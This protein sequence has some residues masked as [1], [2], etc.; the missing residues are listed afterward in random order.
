MQAVDERAADSPPTPLSAPS[1]SHPK[2]TALT[3]ATINTT[4]VAPISTPTPA[5]T[6]AATE[7]ADDNAVLAGAASRLPSN[8]DTLRLVEQADINAPVQLDSG[9]GSSYAS[10]TGQQEPDTAPAAAAAAEGTPLQ[11]ATHSAAAEQM[12][13]TADG[14]STDRY[15]ADDQ[16]PQASRTARRDSVSVEQGPATDSQEG[17]QARPGATPTT[18]E[19]APAPAPPQTLRTL[20]PSQEP[21]QGFP[22]AEA[23][24]VT[25]DG[26]S[27]GADSTSQHLPYA[28]HAEDSNQA[29]QQG[30]LP[31]LAEGHPA[32]SRRTPIPRPTQDQSDQTREEDPARY[33]PQSVPERADMPPRAVADSWQTPETFL[34]RSHTSLPD[35]ADRA[36]PESA[37]PQSA[38]RLSLEAMIPPPFEF[39][40]PTGSPNFPVVPGTHPTSAFQSTDPLVF[41]DAV[42]PQPS[43]GGSEAADRRSRP[44]QA[45]PPPPSGDDT[46]A[47]ELRGLASMEVQRRIDQTAAHVQQAVNERGAIQLPGVSMLEGGHSDALARATGTLRA[48]AAGHL[49]E[50]ATL[51]RSLPAHSG[52]SWTVL[53]EGV[54]A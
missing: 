36:A 31:L 47:P 27:A 10:G 54:L 46:H 9:S 12:S 17:Q 49:E 20:T 52:E 6:P 37:A 40:S 19:P 25:S 3:A 42:P 21:T 16:G 43:S 45:Q 4:S 38:A 22:A 24:S 5:A 29:A 14:E 13:A 18:Q 51:S 30:R 2:T 15:A 44:Q 34:P 11:P 26:L 7:A 39:G 32:G 50:A 41:S 28:L 8:S 53:C 23:A 33:L 35:Q 1:P 48:L